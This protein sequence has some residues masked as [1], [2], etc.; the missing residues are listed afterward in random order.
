M[1]QPGQSCQTSGQATLWMRRA[2]GQPSSG[3]GRAHR[4]RTTKNWT[5]IAKKHSWNGKQAGQ[6]SN[7]KA[8]SY[9]FPG[10][11]PRCGDVPLLPVADKV[12]FAQVSRTW[13]Q[14]EVCAEV[15]RAAAPPQFMLPAMSSSPHHQAWIVAIAQTEEAACMLQAKS[16]PQGWMMFPYRPKGSAASEAVAAV[17]AAEV[18]VEPVMEA[19]MEADVEADVEEVL[20]DAEDEV[21]AEVDQLEEEAVVADFPLADLVL[22]WPLPD[23]QPGQQVTFLPIGL[24]QLPPE[25]KRAWTHWTERLI[26]NQIGVL[27]PRYRPAE[28]KWPCAVDCRPAGDPSPLPMQSRVHSGLHTKAVLDILADSGTCT[29]VL[30]QLQRAWQR[31]EFADHKVVALVDRTS[32]H[33]ALSWARILAVVSA[34]GLS[35]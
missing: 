10:G 13:T 26:R 3:R 22:T 23:A 7:P 9:A 12:V 6:A 5:P 28:G 27:A 25:A 18:E 1:T 14:A 30:L 19:V 21:E 24:W 20:S 32:G 8:W 33:E 35:S 2:P 4:A 11:K 31:V 17:A 29:H 16:L 15:T 34:P